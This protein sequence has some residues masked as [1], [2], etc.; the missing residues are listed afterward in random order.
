[1]APLPCALL[2]CDR[3][4][5]TGSVAVTGPLGG[6]RWHQEPQAQPA[7]AD[8]LPS[9]VFLVTRRR[10]PLLLASPFTVDTV[11]RGRGRWGLGQAGTPRTPARALHTDSCGLF[12]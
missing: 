7:A 10:C 6:P 11:S 2:D 1:M 3:D 8:P 5:V 9:S 4:T 12:P